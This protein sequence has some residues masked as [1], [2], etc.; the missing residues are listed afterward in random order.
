MEKEAKICTKCGILRL[1]TEFN[2]TDKTHGIHH[3]NCRECTQ[4]ASKIS[5]RKRQ[6]FYIQENSRLKKRRKRKLLLF[7]RDYFHSHPCT[8]CGISDPLVLQFDHVSGEKKMNIAAMLASA[9]H[10]ETILS[11][12]EKCE[13]RCANC[14]LCKTAKERGYYK[15]ILHVQKSP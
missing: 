4:K 14:H 11:E 8:D 2:F 1:L 10:Q 9:L 13:V 7:L 15:H 5:Y 3:S 6:K 12:I